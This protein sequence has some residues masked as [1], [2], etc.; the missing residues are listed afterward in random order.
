M[1][2]LWVLVAVLALTALAVSQAGTAEPPASK[3]VRVIDGDTVV[4]MLDGKETT[5]RL[6]GVDMPETVHPTKPVEAYG[7]EASEFTRNLLAGESVYVEYEPGPSKLDRYGRTLA[8]LYRAPDRLFINLEIIRQ[9]YG[10]AYTEYP[11]ARMEQFREAERKAREADKGLWRPESTAP[12]PTEQSDLGDVLVT[13]DGKEQAVKALEIK[14]GMLYYAVSIQMGSA[15]GTGALS[16][17]L[18]AVRH[19]AL[20]Q[21][22]ATSSV[23]QPKPGAPAAATAV[24]PV[25]V[26]GSGVRQAPA[27]AAQD[28]DATVYVT[29][30]GTKY[31]RAGCSSLRQSQIPMTLADAKARGYTPCSVCDPPR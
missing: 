13:A 5:V 2:R 9:G 27:P 31:H 11:F 15:T 14:D 12:P 3:V 10:H 30:T 20:R 25:V 22:T 21:V 18:G 23:V 29:R 16:I 17:P 19:L 26:P 8:Y 6:I 28:A 7:K 1:Q 4:L 24:P